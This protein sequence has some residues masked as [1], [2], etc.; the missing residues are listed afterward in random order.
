MHSVET[1]VLE[2]FGVPVPLGSLSSG[3]SSRARWLA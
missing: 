1:R 2:D 3:A